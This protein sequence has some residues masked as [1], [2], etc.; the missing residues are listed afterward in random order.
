MSVLKILIQL[1]ILR[2]QSG[3]DWL[4]KLNKIIIFQQQN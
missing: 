4:K 3:F 2:E 1:Q